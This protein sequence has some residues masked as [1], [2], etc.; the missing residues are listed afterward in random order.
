MNL[1]EQDEQWKSTTYCLWYVV[2]SGFL[3]TS[4]HIFHL[5]KSDFYTSKHCMRERRLNLRRFCLQASCVPTRIDTAP[6]ECGIVRNPEQ[7]FAAQNYWIVSLPS[8]YSGASPKTANW[9]TVQQP[10]DMGTINI[11]QREA[12]FSLSQQKFFLLLPQCSGE[13]SMSKVDVEWEF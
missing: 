12:V 5:W 1:W 9:E 7:A 4:E 2:P 10:L 13:A 11:F 3:V 8:Q 6:A